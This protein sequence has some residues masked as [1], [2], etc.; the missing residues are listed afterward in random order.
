[1][2]W[3]KISK[4]IDFEGWDLDSLYLLNF[5]ISI[6]LLVSI[7]HFFKANTSDATIISGNIIGLSSLI[8]LYIFA[9]GIF[10]IRKKFINKDIHLKTTMGLILIFN[11]FLIGSF[12][13][14]MGLITK[15]NEDYYLSGIIYNSFNAAMNL[16]FLLIPLF[17]IFF[18]W[19]TRGTEP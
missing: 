11:I 6:F 2:F 19:I 5:T 9:Y 10:I 12:I 16:I 17:L 3:K 8:S 13:L 14:L 18:P 7:E 1:M 4:A 15:Y